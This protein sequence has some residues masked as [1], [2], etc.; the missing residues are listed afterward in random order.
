MLPW[1][2]AGDDFPDT[3][4]ALSDPNGLLAAGADL[5]LTTLLRAYSHG[6]F[7][8]FDAEH[9]PVLWWSPSPRC[10]FWPEQIHC[11]RSLRR[12]I[13]KH[14]LEIRFDHA[15]ETVMR[16]CAT[17]R[18]EGEEG[19]WIGEEMIEAY[20]QLHHAGY[21]HCLEVWNGNDLAGAIYGIQLG[22][23][24]FGESMVSPQPQGSKVALNALGR[25]APTLGIALIDAQVE[26]PH[27]ISMGATHLTRTEFESYLKQWVAQ[28][29]SANRWPTAALH[30]QQLLDLLT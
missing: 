23:V 2:E 14:A 28:P 5:S 27:L 8:W 19:G 30:S 10:V 15:F 21:A 26:N 12:H 17:P 4:S 18:C 22:Q 16:A 20:L 1:L 7:P 9:D 13:R 25:L 29:V 24:F 3:R 6:I 11:S